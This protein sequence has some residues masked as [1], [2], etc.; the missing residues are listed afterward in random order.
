MLVT[1]QPTR[2]VV[3]GEYMEV[4]AGTRVER[5]RTIEGAC[6][7]PHRC[8]LV[9]GAIQDVGEAVRRHKAGVDATEFIERA[10]GAAAQI[11]KVTEPFVQTEVA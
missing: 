4:K 11:L 5:P 3:N 9:L 10:R 8:G 7:D 1:T 2:W 6:P